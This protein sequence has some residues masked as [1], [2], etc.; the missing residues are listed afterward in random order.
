VKQGVA[1]K[2]NYRYV[3]KIKTN[4]SSNVNTNNA[5]SLNSYP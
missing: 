1:S 5:S 2:G 4:P 3:G